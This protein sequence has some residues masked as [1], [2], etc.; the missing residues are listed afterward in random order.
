MRA[1]VGDIVYE[2]RKFVGNAQ[3]WH[4]A[5]LLQHGSILLEPQ[6]KTWTAIIK[7][8]SHDSLREKLKS[9][10]TS[11]REILGRS[12]DPGELKRAIEIGMAEALKVEL[13]AGELSPQEWALAGEIASGDQQGRPDAENA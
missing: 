5:S 4:G 8:D 6:E 12:I 2:G 1:A 13:Q 11:L 3:T 10:I 7:T 9:R